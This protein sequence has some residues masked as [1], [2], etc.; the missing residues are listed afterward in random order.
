[1]VGLVIN[2]A[3]NVLPKRETIWQWPERA[4]DETRKSLTDWS[5]LLSRLTKGAVPDYWPSHIWK[6]AIIIEITTPIFFLFLLYRFEFTWHLAL[7]SLYTTI[8]IL[9][10]VTDLEHRLIFNVVTLPAILFSIAAAFFTPNL[11]WPM[12]LTGGVTAFI[13]TYGLW[14]LGALL[15]GHGA[16]GAGD[17]TLAT[18]LGFILGVPQ[19]ILTIIFTVF[20]GAFVALVLLITRRVTRKSFIP[21]GPFLTITGWIM[22]IWG[23]EISQYYF[24]N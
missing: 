18:F 3:A 11:F 6:R 17:I 5:I 4:P 9:I 8:L 10:T 23:S 13:T 7:V 1:V 19:I 22:L 24:G 14:L 16:L 12:A 21:Y 15:Y 2:H 20:L